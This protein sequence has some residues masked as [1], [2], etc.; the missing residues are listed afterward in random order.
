M[1]GLEASRRLG[2]RWKASLEAAAFLDQ[3]EDRVYYDLR[4]DDYIRLDL[5][6]YF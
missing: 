4:D 1:V 3:D 2:T 5:T 6:Y